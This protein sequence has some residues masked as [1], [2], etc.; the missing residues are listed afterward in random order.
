MN[1]Q[2]KKNPERL[3][4]IRRIIERAKE[5]ASKHLSL[6]P[7]KCPNC[8]SRR[9]R[10]FR[11]LFLRPTKTND[12]ALYYTDRKQLYRPA[13]RCAR[14]GRVSFFSPSLARKEADA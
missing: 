5:H 14:C 4:A 8:G 13:L 6:G 1:T 10:E 9:M 3:G 12:G 2:K 7:H 11:I